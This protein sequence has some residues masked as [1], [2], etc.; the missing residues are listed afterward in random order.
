MLASPTSPESIAS[1]LA[2]LRETLPDR[3]AV[4]YVPVP[5]PPGASSGS[6]HGALTGLEDDDHTQYHTDARGDLRYSLLGHTHADK[7]NLSGG[8][9]FTGTQSFGGSGTQTFTAYTE[10]GSIGILCIG[11]G[12]IQISTTV[13]GQIN[14]GSGQT[15]SLYNFNLDDCDL[16]TP[17]GGALTNC[18]DYPVAAE[19]CN[20]S[21][22]TSSAS[23]AWDAATVRQPTLTLAHNTTITLSNL[24]DG[25]SVS[26][27]GTM[28]GSGGYT[29]GIAH[30]G[31]TVREMGG[32]LAD[33][34]GLA[35]GDLFEIS[36][37]RVG[38][39]LR[40]W[41]SIFEV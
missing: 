40:V 34:A 13:N 9:T 31:L 7:A 33:I 36:C 23:I 26:L 16:G 39:D 30:S 1:M 37:K 22:L 29:V 15:G 3:R 41:V 11:T 32:A 10:N 12:N 5:G 19:Y 27:G 21:V 35:A 24:T 8:N 4:V 18:T 38:S 28:G 25:Q 6:D 2:M 17:L 20:T 14:I